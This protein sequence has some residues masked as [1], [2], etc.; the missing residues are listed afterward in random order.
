M[1]KRLITE[2]WYRFMNEDTGDDPVD[3]LLKD[4]EKENPKAF[5]AMQAELEEFDVDP[6]EVTPDQLY[7]VFDKY[8]A[9]KETNLMTNRGTN[10][11]DFD[12]K[13]FNQ[14]FD[15]TGDNQ[16]DLSD[17]LELGNKSIPYGIYTG[18]MITGDVKDENV[19]TKKATV[20]A[21]SAPGIFR[22]LSDVDSAHTTAPYL[23]VY[24]IP[25]NSEILHYIFDPEE[26][27][28]MGT[29]RKKPEPS[30]DVVEMALQLC[31]NFVQSTDFFSYYS[32]NIDEE[33]KELTAMTAKSSIKIDVVDS[34]EKSILGQM[35]LDAQ[36]WGDTGK[37]YIT[38]TDIK[39][40]I[41]GSLGFDERMED[42][43]FALNHMPML[44]NATFV[45]RGVMTG[46]QQKKLMAMLEKSKPH[47][48]YKFESKF[49]EENSLME[50][51]ELVQQIKRAKNGR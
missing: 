43:L 15:V 41:G 46:G 40:T 42:L 8:A 37:K 29:P 38:T 45:L 50:D 33:I 10:P 22:S 32:T 25:A 27:F 35:L 24:M 39:V 4:M 3:K 18:A 2:N 26:A 6:N 48:N 9:E 47:Y 20:K 12:Q 16:F 36:A 7:K 17:V 34:G 49:F 23:I 13:K 5:A 1:S 21:I 30:E 14:R 44:V 28:S 31:S 11:F 51:Y 19:S